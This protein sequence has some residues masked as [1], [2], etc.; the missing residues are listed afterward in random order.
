M[1]VNSSGSLVGAVLESAGYIYQANLLDS[2]GG[3]L[4]DEIGALI[5]L[6]GVAIVIVQFTVLKSAKM[7]PWLLIG[8]SLFFAVILDRSNLD[9][10]RWS[11]GSNERNQ[12]DVTTGV[13]KVTDGV[14]GG[15]NVSTVFKRYVNMI[16]EVNRA[17]VDT[18]NGVQIENDLWFIVKGQLFGAMTAFKEEDAG[19][20]GLIHYG[21]TGHCYKVIQ[22]ARAVNNP[23]YR[24]NSQSTDLPAAV[25]NSVDKAITFDVKTQSQALLDY[26]ESLKLKEHTFENNPK[27][28]EY[29]KKLQLYQGAQYAGAAI[30]GGLTSPFLTLAN[31][32]LFNNSIDNTTLY[33]CED[34]WGYTLLGI[35][36]KAKVLEKELAGK[37]REM[38]IE[39]DAI[40]NLLGQASGLPG[41]KLLSSGG[42]SPIAAQ[43]IARILAKYFLRNEM[44][45]SDM[46]SRIAEF[47]GRNDIRNIQTRLEGD[48]SGSERDRLG[49][50]EWSEK[51]RLAHAAY[52]MPVY[53]GLILYFLGLTFPFFALLLLIPGK[54]SGFLMWFA[55]WFWAKSWDIGLAVVMQL[56]TIFWSLYAVQKQRM[57]EK[58]FIPDDLATAM[59][60]LEQMDPT[61]QLGGYYTMLAIC[62]LAIPPVTANLVLGGMRGGS[63]IISAGINQFSDFFGNN[64]GGKVQ[65]GVITQL[66][67]DA[68]A[69]KDLRGLAYA[70]GGKG[71]QELLQGRE[72]RGL[73][74]Q[75]QLAR[76]RLAKGV[77][78]F[79]TDL[80]RSV[81]FNRL[82]RSNHADQKA[83]ISGNDRSVQISTMEGTIN[84]NTVLSGGY[85]A[86]PSSL[87]KLHH[88]SDLKIAKKVN[89]KE[90]DLLR[91]T[92]TSETAQADFEGSVDAMAYESHRLQGIFGT[93][94]V[95]WVVDGD[96]GSKEEVQRHLAEFDQRI[97]ILRA[98]TEAGKEGVDTILQGLRQAGD[99]FN[100]K[101][102]QADV[103]APKAGLSDVGAFVGGAAIGAG[104][105]PAVNQFFSIFRDP[106]NREGLTTLEL[107][108]LEAEER[109]ELEEDLRQAEF[110]FPGRAR[111]DFTRMMQRNLGKGIENYEEGTALSEL[112]NHERKYSNFER[113]G[114]P[115]YGTEGNGKSLRSVNRKGNS[116]KNPY[117]SSF[118]TL[119]E[120][121]ENDQ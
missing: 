99:E 78:T 44:Q 103:E 70:V 38:G 75:S 66:K 12:G 55:L 28:V 16:S 65:Q 87:I 32:L 15:A 39:E 121:D 72:D 63:N 48:Y 108:E 106:K 105:R 27:V 119:E 18:I 23:L 91:A 64:M 68:I 47:A 116:R 22:D 8:P 100:G 102:K 98:Y 13:K 74:P 31:S 49:V 34:I 118:R 120:E 77:S 93:I 58:D 73:A 86:L 14:S 85:S 113:G 111:E 69:L 61:F 114:D 51:E 101:A 50:A 81:E 56:D 25:K 36:E 115:D 29:I 46:G 84:T 20:L 59:V 80:G 11:F 79:E 67:S 2:L 57:G 110:M 52:S 76:E 19:L 3:P 117:Q 7:A 9:Q 24:G 33:S 83:R 42:P 92:A 40:R 54:A 35:L 26:N 21:L 60:A 17:V 62:V 71:R 4:K 107:Q 5:Y 96:E 112:E 88:L 41:G 109:R 94:P 53:Q 90:F 45:S 6:L 97:E 89:E 104:F 43:D 82:S 1:P 37:A 30:G 95:P 10:A